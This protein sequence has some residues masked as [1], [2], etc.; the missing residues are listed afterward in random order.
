MNIT[1]QDYPGLRRDDGLSTVCLSGDGIP[2]G[3]R[4][5]IDFAN[6]RAHVATPPPVALDFLLVASACYASDKLMNRRDT[7]DRWTRDF[8][9][10]VPV[11]D[12][13]LW[14][15]AAKYLQ[16][17]LAFLSGDHWELDF[18]PLKGQ[19]YRRPPWR[20]KT[21]LPLRV[22]Q[23]DAVCLF[24][25]GLDSLAGTIDLL[26][27][28]TK[29]RVLL[30]SHYD[31]PAGE[32][33]D[34]LAPMRAPYP[35]RVRQ[36]RA[37]IRL[38]PVAG[39]EA[40]LRTRSLVFL[41]LG[42][43]AAAGTGQEVPLYAYE[44][45]HIALNVPLTPSRAGSCSTRTMHPYFLDTVVGAVRQVGIGNAVI[46]PYEMKTKG[47]CVMQCGNR[48]LLRELSRL[49]VSCSHPSRKQH[50]LRKEARNCGYC[51][52]CLIRRGALHKAGWDS[53]DDYGIDVCAG[54]ISPRIA[55]DSGDDLR[56]VLSF[57]SERRNVQDLASDILRV[58]SVSDLSGSA[59][60]VNRGADEIRTLFG[61]K[62]NAEIRLDAGI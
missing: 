9:I 30:I 51:F 37:R 14:R 24:S 21:T 20:K 5:D 61:D 22:F 50:W 41:A 56:A 60:M 23:P 42:L 16:D 39:V 36:A 15:G 48:T 6:M 45:G 10:T 4:L 54:E 1:V 13:D 25:G 11:S 34:L 55:E 19:L 7:P 40:T 38:D 2:Q 31:A 53:G 3:T 59:S 52:P 57:L 8:A 46:R 26:E 12:P 28:H 43:C 35:G 47:E 27:G 58:A 33:V 18:V 29:P 49:S 44:N 17:A 32:Q 62:G